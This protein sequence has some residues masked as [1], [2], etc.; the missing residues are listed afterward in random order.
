LF[1]NFKNLLLHKWL[2]N[3]YCVKACTCIVYK[4]NFIIDGTTPITSVLK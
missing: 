3:I 4:C 1:S 2:S